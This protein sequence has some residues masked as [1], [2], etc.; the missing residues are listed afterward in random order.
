[1]RVSN[2]HLKYSPDTQDYQHISTCGPKIKTEICCFVLL[3]GLMVVLLSPP[4]FSIFWKSFSV[5]LTKMLSVWWTMPHVLSFFFIFLPTIFIFFSK[6]L[7]NLANKVWGSYSMWP[8]AV[9]I[10]FEADKTVKRTS[11]LVLSNIWWINIYNYFH[12]SK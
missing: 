12:H 9:F 6:L 3:K 10:Y 11:L 5:F 4:Y 8:W 7:I 1:M 2:A